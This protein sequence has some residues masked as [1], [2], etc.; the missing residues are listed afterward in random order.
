MRSIFSD[1][2]STT[3]VTTLKRQAGLQPLKNRRMFQRLKL[4]FQIYN[5]IIRIDKSKY[6]KPKSYR[7]DRL[8]HP[9]VLTA[10]DARINIFK[11][12]FFVQAV[13]LWNKL[14]ASVVALESLSEFENAISVL[15]DL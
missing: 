2:R 8:H 9:K 5:N 14:P 7:L 3:S 13:E 11:Q 15:F 4:F 1:F 10:I 6:V 12:S